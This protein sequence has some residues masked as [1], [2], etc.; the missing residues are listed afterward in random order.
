MGNRVV[1]VHV[2]EDRTG[3]DRATPAVWPYNALQWWKAN[4]EASVGKQSTIPT[5][6]ENRI[7]RVKESVGAKMTEPAQI[8]KWTSPRPCD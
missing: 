1:D 7:E 5:S 6:K 3:A 4:V 2:A 8:R